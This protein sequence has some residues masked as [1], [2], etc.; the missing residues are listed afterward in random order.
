M[1]RIQR[2]PRSLLALFGIVGENPPQALDD[3]VRSVVDIKAEVLAELP[4][5][6][7]FANNAAAVAG[8]NVTVTVPSGEV[9]FVLGGFAFVPRAL[10]VNNQVAV[11]WN[12]VTLDSVTTWLAS[13]ASGSDTAFTR[14]NPTRPIVSVAGDV[15]TGRLNGTDSGVAQSLTLFVQF[16]RIFV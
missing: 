4:T 16:K 8:T 11:S 14:Y 2:V 7:A 13:F 5:D 6:S 3:S 1:S 10:N 12:G 9:W 15:W